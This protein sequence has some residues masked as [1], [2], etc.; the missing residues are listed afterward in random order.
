MVFSSARCC[1]DSAFP[2]Y[3]ALSLCGIALERARVRFHCEISFS[4]VPLC[5]VPFTSCYTSPNLSDLAENLATKRTEIFT[6]SF[7]HAQG[8]YRML[9]PRCNRVDMVFFW[10]GG[11]G[12]MGSFRSATAKQAILQFQF[13]FRE[14]IT[15][16]TVNDSQTA[17]NVLSQIS[18][19]TINGHL[20]C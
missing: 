6:V 10:G 13:V 18:V 17:H 19:L 5:D 7:A 12:G 20:L 8:Q 14:S 4:G 1:R 16:I 11:G 2:V 15:T 9:S 3:T